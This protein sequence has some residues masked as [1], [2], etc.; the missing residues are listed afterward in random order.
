MVKCLKFPSIFKILD[1]TYK[2]LSLWNYI[3]YFFHVKALKDL[4]FVSNQVTQYQGNCNIE[5]LYKTR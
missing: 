1:K 2:K 5:I 4:L 3:I